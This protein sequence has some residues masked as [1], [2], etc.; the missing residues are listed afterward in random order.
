ME[1]PISQGL[2]DYCQLRKTSLVEKMPEYKLTTLYFLKLDHPR[3]IPY[4]TNALE[5]VRGQLEISIFTFPLAKT[6]LGINK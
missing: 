4:G 1:Y 3:K 2:K 5:Y 6:L